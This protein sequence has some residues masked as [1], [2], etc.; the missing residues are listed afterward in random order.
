MLPV[1]V[2]QRLAQDQQVALFVRPVEHV[3]LRRVRAALLALGFH[4][5]RR[6]IGGKRPSLRCPCFVTSRKCDPRFLAGAVGS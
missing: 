6:A 4:L 2:C 1:S 5:Q 3:A